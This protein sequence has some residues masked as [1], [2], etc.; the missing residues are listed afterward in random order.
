MQTED[1]C[2]QGLRFTSDYRVPA[3]RFRRLRSEFGPNFDCI[4]ITSG[5]DSQNR[6][7]RKAHSVLTTEPR[8]HHSNSPAGRELEDAA[9]RVLKLL[10]NRLHNP[11][12]DL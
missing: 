7:R 9:Q 8:R 4:E 1:L 6:I 11:N 10:R 3:E 2:V 5:P 12:R